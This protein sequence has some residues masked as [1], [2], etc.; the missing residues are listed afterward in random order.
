MT[1]TNKGRTPPRVDSTLQKG[2]QIL[3]A[4]ATSQR[5]LGIT[6]LSTLLKLNK[7]NVH[8]LIKTLGVMNY[9]VQDENRSYRAS[10]K[11]WKLGSSV[12][13][14]ANLVQLCIGEMNK[15]AQK[16]GESVHLSVL[17][18]LRVL[19]VEKIDSAQSVRAYSERGGS[20]PLHCTAT[21]KV[22]L[23]YSYDALREPISKML[24]KHTTKTI[25]SIKTLDGEV[26]AIRNAGYSV[27]MGEYRADVG[28]VAAPIFDSDG[29]NVAAI[30]ISGPTS[31][32]TKPLI[33]E[34]VA[35]VVASAKTASATIA[36]L[37]R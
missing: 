35:I 18:G 5:S 1:T 8:R 22:L 12:M 30:G 26:A 33:K 21:G 4:L 28:G 10:M 13:S 37:Q 11:L 6:E 34:F 2:L 25:T 36:S 27:N 31:R 24:L 3:E 14:H 15:L 19:Y 17:D 32:L 9:V 23:A 7:S 16:T 29:K 20:A